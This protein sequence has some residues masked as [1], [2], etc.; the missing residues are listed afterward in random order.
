MTNSTERAVFAN[1]CFWCTEAIFTRLK[2][3]QSVMPGYTGGTLKDPSYEEVCTGETGHAEAIEIIFDPTQITYET[4]LEVFF[5]T[6]D[7]TSLNRQ[8]AD[9]GT[10]YRSGIFYTSD[11]Q[12][13][14][15]EEVK[16]K[17]DESGEFYK[18]I[19]TEITPLDTFYKAESY[20]QEYYRKNR[21]QPYCSIVIVP[22]IKHFLE[23]YSDLI[24]K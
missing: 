17:L 14:T 11:E 6:H 4:L 19:V 22:K 13:K 9:V 12:K 15:A 3:V 21:H 10:Q 2:G 16:K 20:H 23:E 7:P 5:H 1:G 8:G 18:P 24:K